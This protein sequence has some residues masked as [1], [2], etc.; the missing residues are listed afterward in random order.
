MEMSAAGTGAENTLPPPP[1]PPTTRLLPLTL[2]DALSRAAFVLGRTK[3]EEGGEEEGC[4]SLTPPKISPPSEP[5]PAV[6]PAAPAADADPEAAEAEAE[7]EED[8]AAAKDTLRVVVWAPE[9]SLPPPSPPP[10]HPHGV[11]RGGAGWKPGRG[12]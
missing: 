9:S 5:A 7:A 1:P 10:Y 12:A 3:A 4:L 8:E 2:C 6:A 11:P